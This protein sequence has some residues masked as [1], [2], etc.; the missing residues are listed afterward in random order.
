MENEEIIE[1]IE[2]N[3]QPNDRTHTR[4]GYNPDGTTR[5]IKR[6]SDEFVKVIGKPALSQSVAD[7]IKD[8]D[9]IANEYLDSA[10]LYPVNGKH[11]KP[12]WADNGGTYWGLLQYDDNVKSKGLDSIFP[13][14]IKDATQLPQNFV[15]M[16]RTDL[17]NLMAFLIQQIQQNYNDKTSLIGELRE[18][19]LALQECNTFKVYQQLEEHFRDLQEAFDIAS[20][21]EENNDGD[22]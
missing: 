7:L 3:P 19:E 22:N 11:Y 4:Y 16:E 2:T 10:V 18:I 20:E 15:T 13:M 1:P 5:W 17:E 6:D 14:V 9:R 12:K 8:V 21:S